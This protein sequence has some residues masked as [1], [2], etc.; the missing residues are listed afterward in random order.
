MKTFLLGFLSYGFCYLLLDAIWLGYIAQDA[1]MQAMAGVMREEYPMPPWIIFYLVYCA[2]VT[3]LVI[4]KNTQN[5][6][7]QTFF[8]GA[9]LGMAAYGAYNLTNY[10]ILDGWQ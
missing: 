8:D 7:K 9:V 5:S 10:A 1:Y 4:M 6:A 3:H 2:A